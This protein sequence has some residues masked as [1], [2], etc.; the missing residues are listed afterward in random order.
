M[1]LADF[2]SP[3]DR[4]KQSQIIVKSKDTEAGGGLSLT[5]KRAKPNTGGLKAQK[6][7]ALKKTEKK[8]K[9][10]KQDEKEKPEPTTKQ[11]ATASAPDSNAQ[12]SSM[13]KS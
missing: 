11:A 2:V 8:L 1:E 3:V 5:I 13:S 4:F 6:E 10:K 12:S 7:V 9:T